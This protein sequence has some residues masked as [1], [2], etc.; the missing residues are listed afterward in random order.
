MSPLTDRPAAAAPSDT[1]AQLEDIMARLSREDT[2]DVAARA[3]LDAAVRALAD[4]LAAHT[5]TAHDVEISRWAVEDAL[6]E[7]RR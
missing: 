1:I 4:A 3:R 5:A 2:S 7:Y 6:K